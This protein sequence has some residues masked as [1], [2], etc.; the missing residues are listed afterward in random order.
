[1]YIYYRY[2]RIPGDPS[3]YAWRLPAAG[4]RPARELPPGLALASLGMPFPGHDL[5]ASSGPYPRGWD[6]VPLFF[7]AAFC[8]P[9]CMWHGTVEVCAVRREELRSDD[10]EPKMRWC[11]P[12]YVCCL[13]ELPKIRPAQHGAS[14][15]AAASRA[16][17][18]LGSALAI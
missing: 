8:C 4:A 14:R 15:A 1:M 17:Q 18:A 3:L 5:H 16:V 10:D 12:L 9:R 11:L 7:V 13:F 2:P 6:D